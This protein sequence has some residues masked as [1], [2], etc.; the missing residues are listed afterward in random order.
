M[1]VWVIAA[2]VLGFGSWVCGVVGVSLALGDL[3]DAQMTLA[4]LAGTIQGAAAA[5]TQLSAPGR[6]AVGQATVVMSAWTWL[7]TSTSAVLISATLSEPPL[8]V[9][10]LTVA[11]LV[12]LALLLIGLWVLDRL[13]RRSDDDS[14]PSS[15]RR[16]TEPALTTTSDEPTSDHTGSTSLGQTGEV[17]GHHQAEAALA[18]L[19]G[20]DLGRTA[21]VVDACREP[22][23]TVA[24]ALAHSGVATLVLADPD[25]E[26]LANLA[27]ELAAAAPDGPE[28]R[29]LVM[30]P[31]DQDLVDRIIE[32]TKPDTIVHAPPRPSELLEHQVGVLSRSVVMST[33]HL[34]DAAVYHS[35]PRVVLFDNRTETA[36][37]RLDAAVLLAEQLTLAAGEEAGAGYGVVRLNG[38]HDVVTVAAGLSRSAGWTSPTA[39]SVVVG[40]DGPIIRP[41]EVEQVD[42]DILGR[43]ADAADLRSPAD[44]R[45]S[46][47][48]D[49]EAALGPASTG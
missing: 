4:A 6:R 10:R 13:A 14:T 26:R 47:A 48:A 45:R 12:A 17:G 43:V 15:T 9:P 30:L 16:L 31:W 42:D 20:A 33:Y 18:R 3:T 41:V 37:S 2:F 8:S 46:A 34:L 25:D 32:E 7:A 22:G 27:A 1:T 21:L 24:H 5:N 35:C 38:P 11:A 28:I 29:P 44:E 40:S 49:V 36:A 19:S 23:K 39:V